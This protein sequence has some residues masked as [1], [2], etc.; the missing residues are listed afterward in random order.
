VLDAA[1]SGRVGVV[2]HGNDCGLLT[3][4]L[5]DVSFTALVLSY[6]RFCCFAPDSQ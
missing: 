4:C 1:L 6:S 2:D 5:Q 3:G